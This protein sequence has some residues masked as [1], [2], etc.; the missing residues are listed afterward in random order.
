MIYITGDTHNTVDMSNVSNKRIKEYCEAV[1]K[2]I[3]DVQVLIIL[4]DFGL[5][6]EKCEID[7]N[8]IHPHRGDDR[9]LLKWYN[10]K[11]FIV[12]ALTGN[13]DNYDMIEQL[14]EVPLYGGMV[15]KVSK[16]I[17]YLKRGNFYEIESHRFLVLGGAQSHDG[18]YRTT[19]LSWWEQ[20][21]WTKDE[22]EECLKK[23]SYNKKEIDYV[24]SHTGTTTGIKATAS[25]KFELYDLEPYLQDPTVAFNDKVDN[26]ISYKKWFF[27]HLHSD[28]GAFH[29]NEIQI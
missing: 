4:G 28:W 19:H 14:P 26:L 12:L 22:Q 11:P 25:S 8:G 5:P 6:W 20:E 21:V 16:N 29:F 7:E 24:L 9:K 1:G 18:S 2:I 10:E 3:S 17:F 23:I 15:K 27:G 13:H